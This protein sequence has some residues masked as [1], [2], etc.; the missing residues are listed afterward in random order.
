MID[1]KVLIDTVLNHW[2][3]DDSDAVSALVSD[4]EEI[5][6]DHVDAQVWNATIG[7]E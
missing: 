5:I 6:N 2:H 4:L 3:T 1:S 7:D